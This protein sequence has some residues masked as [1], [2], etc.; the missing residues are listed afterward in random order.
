MKANIEPTFPTQIL[1]NSE[2]RNAQRNE[3]PANL[4]NSPGEISDK[5]DESELPSCSKCLQYLVNKEIKTC[6]QCTIA[7]YCSKECQQLDWK[8]HKKHCKDLKRYV[9]SRREEHSKQDDEDDKI[10]LERERADVHNFVKCN[11][12]PDEERIKAWLTR[13]LCKNIGF[14]EYTELKFGTIEQQLSL[15][16]H[17]HI[18]ATYEGLM[19]ERRIYGE[20]RRRGWL[21]AEIHGKKG[22][23]FNF[24]ILNQICNPKHEI[25]K[26]DP[27]Y[28]T[29]PSG[30]PCQLIPYIVERIIWDGVHQWVG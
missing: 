14:V 28:Q 7:I 6:G 21:I 13:E 8:M 29:N 24:C 9:V 27:I 2:P 19:D 1:E 11:P 16:H 3:L 25:F 17:E 15:Y 20:A 5:S 26:Y 23:Q 18:K 12:W 4:S 22:M 10:A 30:H